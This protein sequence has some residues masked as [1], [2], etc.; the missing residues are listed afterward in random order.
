MCP[1]N[2]FASDK[3]KKWFNLHVR[4]GKHLTQITRGVN[5]C[6]CEFC[7]MP[8]RDDHK[9]PGFCPYPKMSAKNHYVSNKLIISIDEHVK[10]SECSSSN[11]TRVNKCAKNV[12]KLSTSTALVLHPCSKCSNKRV[13]CR[14]KK[15]A[16]KECNKWL[17]EECL[18]DC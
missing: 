16:P 9:F 3:A 11:G 7:M 8:L 6:A 4:Q 2:I 12:V 10:G 14:L 5:G 17:L 1:K 18:E 13:L 15:H